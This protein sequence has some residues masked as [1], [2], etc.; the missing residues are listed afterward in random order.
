MNGRLT[1]SKLSVVIAVAM[2]GEPAWAEPPEAVRGAADQWHQWR[3]PS[4]QGY[5]DDPHVPLKWS[6]TENLAWKTPLPGRGNS[7][8]VVW[9]DRVFLTAASK[10][11]KE[12][13]VLCLR[14]SDGKILWHELAA[15]DPDPAKSHEWNGHASASCTTDGERVYAFFG[16]PGLFCYDVNGKLLWQHHFGIFTTE[17]GWGTA[18]SPFLY[19]DLVIQNCDND[20]PNWL[21]PGHDP[22]EAAPAAL[23]ALDKRTGKVKWQT[24]RDQGRGFSTPRLVTLGNGRQDL[25]LNGPLGVW[26]YDPSTGKEIWHCDRTDPNDRARFGEP[27]PVSNG[28]ML[29][30]PSGRDGPFQA[31]RLGGSGDVSKSHLA[32]QVMRKGHR[33]VSS[34]IYANDLVFAADKDGML[35]CHDPKDGKML[36]AVRSNAGKSLASPIAIRGKLLFL[37]DTGTTIVVVPERAYKEVGRNTLGEGHDLE[38]EAS[39]AVARGRLFIRSQTHL[40]CFAERK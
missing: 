23:V 8:P 19:G 20:G 28:A 34:Q 24:P 10:D 40:Y 37:F 9:G 18:A 32:W 29:F 17:T 6:E 35:T 2:T 11:G 31:I 4:G 5:A 15:K 13:Y 7:S 3:G 38:F 21:P 39:P 22:K 16:T 30:A 12:R 26:A 14:A 36:Y 33:D 27:I 1:C 25:I